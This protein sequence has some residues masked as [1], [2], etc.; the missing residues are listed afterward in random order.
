[1]SEHSWLTNAIEVG[2]SGRLHVAFSNT[3][4][5]PRQGPAARYYGASHLYSDDCGGTWRQFGDRA[6]LVL[7][8]DARRLHRIEGPGM[9]PDRIE[10]RYNSSGPLALT[11]YYHKMVLSNPIVDARDRPW[12]ILHNLLTGDARLCRHEGQG[13]WVGVP[14]RAPVQM[15]LPGHRIQHCGQ[16]SRR[17]DGS[18]EA[19]L[20]VSPEAEPAWGALGT[21]LVRLVA[22]ADGRVLHEELVCPPEPGM[23]HW[24]PSLERWR[25]HTPVARPALLYTR[26]LNAGGG[27]NV[28]DVKT[29]V[30][31][32]VQQ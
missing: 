7:P 17:Q 16:L 6:P 2:Q 10:A 30:W 12:L 31:L 3:L 23:P 11:S 28:N 27:G 22:D 1:V 29:Q 18:I 8:A 4:P 32:Q 13:S 5:V 24:L 21:T 26:G 25:P 9:P 15:L 19:V 20:M 14:L